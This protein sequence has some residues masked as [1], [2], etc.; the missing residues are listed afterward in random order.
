VT[1]TDVVVRPAH[2]TAPHAPITPEA[3]PPASH[4]APTPP[5]SGAPASNTAAPNAAASAAPERPDIGPSSAT[6]HSEA[7]APSTVSSPARSDLLTVVPLWDPILATKGVDPRDAYVERF[8]LG[9]LGPSTVLL[10]RRFARGLEERPTGFRVGLADTSL[11]L[12]LGKGT[13]RNAAISRTIDRA[14]N[15][16]LLRADQPGQIEVRTHMPL[17]PSRF[18]RQLPPLLRTTHA[19]WIAEHRPHV[20]EQ[21][22]QRASTQRRRPR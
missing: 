19:E 16:G 17:L 11:A 9:V 14:A 15:F 6:D 5:E 8:W 20:A 18:V 22:R 3:N 21:R 12:G 1:Y 4:P 7:P 2:P 13:G 10:L